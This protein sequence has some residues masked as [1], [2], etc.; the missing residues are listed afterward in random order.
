MT[1]ELSVLAIYSA[2]IH[3]RVDV[4]VASVLMSDI[5]PPKHMNPPDTP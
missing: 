4:G 5:C 1:V 2:A 3:V